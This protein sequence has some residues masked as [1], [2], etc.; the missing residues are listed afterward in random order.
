[1]TIEKAREILWSDYEPL[2]E[3]KILQ[4]IKLFESL[5]LFLIEKE[6]NPH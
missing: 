5:S 4:I 1:M 2:D 3:G 6:L